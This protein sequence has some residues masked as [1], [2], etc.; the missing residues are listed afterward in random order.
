MEIDNTLV[1]DG[2]FAPSEKNLQHALSPKNIGHLPRHKGIPLCHYM[3]TAPLAPISAVFECIKRWE[4][5]PDQFY[6]FACTLILS[7]KAA[8]PFV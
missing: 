8:S 3:I 4:V 2:N 5:S 6:P 1:L 7:S